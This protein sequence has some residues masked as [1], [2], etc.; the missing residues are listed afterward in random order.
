MYVFYITAPTTPHWHM[1][2]YKSKCES[3]S[4]ALT[5]WQW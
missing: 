3:F 5:L 4:L 1:P 2:P